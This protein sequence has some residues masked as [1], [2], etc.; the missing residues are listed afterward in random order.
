VDKENVEQRLNSAQK[1]LDDLRTLNR[2]N[3]PGANPWE[4]QQLVQEFFF[5]LGG[6]IDV[7]AQCVNDAKVLGLDSENVSVSS[8]IKALPPADPIAKGLSGLYVSTRGAAVPSDPYSEEGLLFRAYNYRHQVTH[9]GTN[10]FL[11]R[12]GSFPPAS[13][14]LDPRDRNL[15]HSDRAAQDEMQLMKN[16]ISQRCRVVLA[17]F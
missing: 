10:P 5:H 6:A 17:L 11:F 9:R 4:R 15:G 16:L 7:L 2:G 3:L 13:F 14:H 1:R 12:V 8:V